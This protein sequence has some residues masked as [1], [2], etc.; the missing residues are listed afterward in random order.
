M[1]KILINELSTRDGN[2]SLMATRMPLADILNIVEKLDKVGFNAIE[3]WG[4]A[5]FD[6]CLRYL[7]EDPWQR[8]REI[9]KRCQNT[10]LSMLLRGQNLVGYTHYPDDVVK[11]FIKKAIENGI[12]I[13]RIFDALNDTRN[14]ECALKATKEY[15][16]HAQC[17]ISYTT[18]PYHSIEYFVD[19][20]QKLDQLGAD[21]ICIK[22][23]AGILTTKDAH[24]LVKRLKEV[25]TLDIN[26]HSHTTA[27]I[28]PLVMQEALLAGADIFDTCL[29]P[30]SQGTS[31][32]ATE[33]FLSI[34]ED[35]GYEHNL[36]TKALNEAFELMTK[37]ANKY[38]DEGLINAKALQINPKILDYQVPGGMLS[39]LTAQLKQQQALDKYEEVLKEIPVV[40][41]QLGYPPLV[42]PLSQMVGTQ[43]VMNVIT[44]VPYKIISNEVKDYVAGNYG[45][46]P[47]PIA[48]N[49]TDLIL[50][51]IPINTKRPADN[52]KPLFKE[53]Q[54]RLANEGYHLSIEEVLS[55]IIFPKLALK[56]KQTNQIV[57]KED[58]YISFN[59]YIKE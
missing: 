17:A 24:H 46:A 49:I 58:D 53:T 30:F 47:Q 39:N 19:L 56:I 48:K 10:K 1:K 8:L 32:L 31:H 54:I 13:I 42:T 33:T 51:G 43:A 41:A 55:Y 50:E 36:D 20:V 14:I 57:N 52:L 6:V 18:S 5:T 15:G 25:T 29:S 38:I 2:Q 44:K 21:S 12:D 16:A 37:Y 3:C 59:I 45:L 34:I 23:M 35:N 4:G 28:T 7:N 11:L 40:R 26:I 22:D 27:G 9:R